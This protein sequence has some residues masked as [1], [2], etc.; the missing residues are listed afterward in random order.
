LRKKLSPQ[1]SSIPLPERNKG[2]SQLAR[3]EDW[4][5]KKEIKRGFCQTQIAL[6]QNKLHEIY[7]LV[8]P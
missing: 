7:F 4:A 2:R 8:H 5:K 3:G 1:I 6:S